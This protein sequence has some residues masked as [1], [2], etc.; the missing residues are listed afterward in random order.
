[1]LLRTI[2]FAAGIIAISTQI[3][4]A[5]RIRH[6]DHSLHWSVINHGKGAFGRDRNRYSGDAEIYLVRGVGSFSRGT[7]S[8][9][10]MTRPM[11]VTPKIIE[12]DALAGGS[13]CM[14]EKGV[15][16]IRP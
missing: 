4:A 13:Q 15:C 11:N 10:S 7:A 14:M 16:V 2:A 8:S 6:A 5:E 12:I 9:V 1:M 3:G